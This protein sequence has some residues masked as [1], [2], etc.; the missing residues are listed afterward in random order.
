MFLVSAKD[1]IDPDGFLQYSL[2]L[3]IPDYNGLD[4]ATVPMTVV[5]LSN[6]P[7]M[8]MRFSSGNNTLLVQAMD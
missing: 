7:D 5:P 4:N 6:S 1:F 3:Y 8:R 2:I